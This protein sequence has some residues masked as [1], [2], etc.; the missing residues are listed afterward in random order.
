MAKGEEKE[1]RKAT[2]EPWQLKEALVIIPFMASA[3][4]LTWEVGFFQV[5]GG[6]S[7]GL[8]TVTEHITFAL[9]VLPIALFL[10]TAV[11][12]VVVQFHLMDRHILPRLVSI[13]GHSR[14]RIRTRILVGALVLNVGLVVLAYLFL[15]SATVLIF[16]LIA[17]T[18]IVLLLIA[19]E[20]LR[21][22]LMNAFFGLMIGF[23][24]AFGLGVD[25]ARGELSSD[26]PLNKISI[27]EKGKA[28]ETEIA[29][30]ILR[31]GERGILYFD[32]SVSQ[33]GFV[34]WDSVKSIDWVR[35]PMRTGFPLK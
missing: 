4:A 31:T 17:C 35:S 30:R 3:L 23:G 32:R 8:F 18:Q 9:Q 21:T 27:G 22:D 6:G 26:R 34:S 29:V 1:V 7:F 5:I 28:A 11:I 13:S 24:G 33:F 19:P 12:S 16:V 14:R 10:S 2:N 25:L 15:P 20:L